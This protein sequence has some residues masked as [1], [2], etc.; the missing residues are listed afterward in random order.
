MGF[1]R[2]SLGG[3]T[4]RPH[5]P[6]HVSSF[7]YHAFQNLLPLAGTSFPLGSPLPLMSHS[8][9]NG[10]QIATRM[11]PTCESWR[12]NLPSL[13]LGDSTCAGPRC[14]T[15][16][17]VRAVFPL[18]R[19]LLT[20]D[21]YDHAAC[22]QAR[23]MRLCREIP[24]QASNY[25]SIICRCCDL[26]TVPHTICAMIQRLH[27]P[28][29]RL[30][31]GT[32]LI[33]GRTTPRLLHFCILLCLTSKGPDICPHH[34]AAG[35]AAYHPLPA[36]AANTRVS[37]SIPTERYMPYQIL[38]GKGAH[39][40]WSTR[41]AENILFVHHCIQVLYLC[42]CRPVMCYLRTLLNLVA[43]VRVDLPILRTAY[44]PINLPMPLLTQPS[45]DDHVPE[46]S[47]HVH[48]SSAL[49]LCQAYTIETFSIRPRPCGS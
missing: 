48:G 4:G 11:S 1:Y 37:N 46:T 26:L 40:M 14:R 6:Q 24:P 15:P 32:E 7:L 16:F 17:S 19:I 33:E 25:I 27:G 18:Q 10:F 38:C 3:L 30:E 42:S 36:R 31:F 20:I 39:P 41:R 43:A 5:C 21:A 44:Q 49:V 12:S 28:H 9:F 22:R 2:L 47:T 8:H 29:L 35:E 13:S 23:C 45:P 34:A